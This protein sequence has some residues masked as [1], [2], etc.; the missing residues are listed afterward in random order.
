MQS[1][2]DLELDRLGGFAPMPPS[3]LEPPK[4][5]KPAKQED[6]LIREDPENAYEELY[7][8]YGGFSGAVIDSDE[9]DLTHMDNKEGKSKYDFGTEQ[10]WEVSTLAPSVQFYMD[11][12]CD[13]AHRETILYEV[14]A[15]SKRCFMYVVH[16][17]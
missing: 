3:E 9:E 6:E 12:A 11:I 16:L 13:S 1:E 5:V 8:N 17:W 15:C 10:E 7:P 4:K 14:D 2:E